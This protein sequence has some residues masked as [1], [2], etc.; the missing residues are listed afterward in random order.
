[1]KNKLAYDEISTL[2]NNTV[3][4]IKAVEST[5]GAYREMLALNTCV[6]VYRVITEQ[7]AATARDRLRD[8]T[9][10]IR[11]LYAIQFNTI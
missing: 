4:E 10:I 6:G 2:I 7:G 11:D 5:L 3:C 8:L 1:M 9:V